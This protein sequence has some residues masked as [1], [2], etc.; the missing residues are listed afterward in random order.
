[1]TEEG[2]I[3]LKKARS[4]EKPI[5]QSHGATDCPYPQ[6]ST[7]AGLP[8]ERIGTKGGNRQKAILVFKGSSLIIPSP[9]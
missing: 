6:Q 7:Q 9:R 4:I 8:K 2:P 1:M 5:T 3:P